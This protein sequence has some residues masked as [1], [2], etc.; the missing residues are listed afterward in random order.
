M[1]D[2]DPVT[3]L[4]SAA[5]FTESAFGDLVSG[6]SSTALNDFL[7]EATR[8][9]ES[10]T[11]RRLAPFTGVTETVRADGIDPDEYAGSSSLPVDI[12]AT[13]GMNYADQVGAMNL[14]RHCWLSEYPPRYQEL[15]T[16]PAQASMSVT[17]IRSYG[18]TMTLSP[19]QI[20]DGPDDQGHVWFQLGQF[21]PV[22]SRLRST[23]SGGY[24]TSPA[25]LVRA[26][27]YI[28]ASIAITE[29]NPATEHDPE[30]LWARAEKWLGPYGRD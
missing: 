12:R 9:C 17:V 20:L 25:D 1:P 21:I 3:P 2:S 13:I 14:V 26:C 15:W 16:Q 23:Y 4:C 5:Q 29:L 30:V 6:V 7:I 11:G 10:I 18:G 27:K 22:G 24:Q 19:A 8:A 28:T